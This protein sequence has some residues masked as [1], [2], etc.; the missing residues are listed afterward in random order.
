[1]WATAMYAGL[2]RGEPAPCGF[3]QWTSRQAS[4]ASSAAMTRAKV[5]SGWSAGWR[6]VP[7]PAVLRDYLSEHL[8]RK[9]R[10]LRPMLRLNR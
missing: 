6:K 3:R 5:K 2:R 1:M 4:S 10:W 7:I 9:T 8:A